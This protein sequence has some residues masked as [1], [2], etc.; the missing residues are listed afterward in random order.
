MEK[1][2]SN[3]KDRVLKIAENKG[4]PKEIFFSELGVSYANFKGI[5]KQ[6]GLNSDTIDKIISKYPEVNLNWLIMGIGEMFSYY[7]IE[8]DLN[9][10]N[11]P[12][13]EYNSVPIYDLT[14]SASVVQVFS[15]VVKAVPIDFLKIPN[16]PL[17]DGAIYINGDSMYPL[18][19][20]GD[21]VLFKKVN[22]KANIIWGEMYVLYINNS[23]DEFFFVKYLQK[24]NRENYVKLVSQNQHHEPVEFPMDSIMQLALVKASVRINSTI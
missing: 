22:D 24:S 23:G 4:I 17:C 6:S 8:K 9:V 11:E 12:R 10:V 2:I 13:L 16:L 3:I 15:D 14:A 7:S 18:L 1:K 20:S 19:K 5:Q 21:L